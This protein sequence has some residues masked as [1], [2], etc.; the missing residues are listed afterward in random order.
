MT[1]RPRV[2]AA[3]GVA[4]TLAL[5]GCTGT[6]APAPNPGS[7]EGAQPQAG[8]PTPSATVDPADVTCENM[9]G[10]DTVAEFTDNDWSVREDPFVILDL[11]LPDGTSC[12]WGDFSS[13]TS[14]DLVL[15]GWAPIDADDAASIQDALVA[16]GWL[17][18][19]DAAGALVTEDPALALRLDADGYG[20]TYRF[21]DGWVT[22]SDTKQGLDLIDVRP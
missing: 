11:E 13:P 17:R 3:V 8:S 10:E 20:M 4:F 2:L 16:E 7:S 18:E 21:G 5:A 14:D 12:T 15:F 19:D 22:V 1:R 6:P 9:L